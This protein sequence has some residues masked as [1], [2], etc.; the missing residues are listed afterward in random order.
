[1]PRNHSAYMKILLVAPHFPPRYTAGVEQITARLATALSARGF[2]VQ[3]ACV[4]SL[5]PHQPEPMSVTSDSVGDVSVHRLS[6]RPAG[7]QS[8]YDDPHVRHWMSGLLAREDF[9]VVHLQSGY[10]LGGATLAA[11]LSAQVPIVVTAHDY[12]FVCPRYTLQQPGGRWCSG[13][14]SAEKC[15]WCLSSDRRWL[16]LAESVTRGG[17]GRFMASL[18]AAGGSLGRAL[19]LHVSVDEVETRERELHALLESADAVLSTSS[20]VAGWLTRYH[21]RARVKVLRSGLEPG[22]G[23]EVRPRADGPLRLVYSGQLTRHK[24]VHVAIAAVRRLA[25]NSVSLHIHGPLER[26]PDYVQQLRRLAEGDDRIVFGG[27]FENARVGEIL[28]DADV[29][30]VPSVWQENYPTVVLEARAQGLPVIASRVGGLPEM[31]DDGVDGVL[32]TAGD[33]AALTEAIS[34]LAGD[35]TLYAS[36]RNAVKTPRSTSDE[37]A[38]LLEVYADVVARRRFGVTAA[39]RAH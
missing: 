36:M 21:P 38:E 19:P 39:G 13:P 4:E 8:S 35:G 11:S 7:F 32:V 24:G 30:V 27:G 25:G 1:M 37:V 26:E 17:L 33:V 12:W 5:N 28:A 3:V 9:D 2:A 15:A 18:L 31:V 6:L 14:E 22:P 29:L 16:R 34:R 10:L 23:R 20:Y